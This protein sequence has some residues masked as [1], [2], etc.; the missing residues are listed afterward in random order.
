MV[1]YV[2]SV[3]SMGGESMLPRLIGFNVILGVPTE[4][5]TPKIPS[6]TSQSVSS[7]VILQAILRQTINDLTLVFRVIHT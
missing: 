4:K 6:F 2:S 1:L 7:N 3:R 5:S